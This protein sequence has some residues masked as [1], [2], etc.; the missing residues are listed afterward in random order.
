ME[1]PFISILENSDKLSQ[2]REHQDAHIIADVLQLKADLDS[3]NQLPMYKGG[4]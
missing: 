1:S 4:V 2:Y 3:K